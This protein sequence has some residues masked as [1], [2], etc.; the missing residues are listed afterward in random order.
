MRTLIFL[1]SAAALAA[2]TPATAKPQNAGKAKA[3]QS[4]RGHDMTR[5][6]DRRDRTRTDANA[7]G[8][9]DYRER[10][11]VDLNRNGV[12]DYRERFVD[13]DRD[14]VDDRREAGNRYGV[15]ACPPGLAKKNNGCLPPGQAK[16]SFEVGQR[17]PSG[18][19][20]YTDYRDLPSDYYTRYNLDDDYRYIR[21]DGSLYEVDPVTSIV[22]RII[23]I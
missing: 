4:H 10:R 15:N 9:P 23:G 1:A 17:V 19:N 6:V 2:V 20:Y 12:P 5:T 21:R 8:I 13:R 7:N 16:K 22:R 3:A 14:G 18:Y 11:T